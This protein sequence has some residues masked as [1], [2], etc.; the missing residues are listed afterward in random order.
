MFRYIFIYDF[1]FR[2]YRLSVNKYIK[3]GQILDPSDAM[4]AL[5]TQI[6]DNLTESELLD[7]NIFRKERLYVE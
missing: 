5:V 2:T 4:D 7:C 3:S 1:L 6:L